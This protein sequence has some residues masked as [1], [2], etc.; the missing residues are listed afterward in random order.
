[1]KTKTDLDVRVLSIVEPIADDLGLRV[2]RLRVMSG[3]RPVLQIMAERISDGQMNVSACEALSR[4]VSS[5]LEVED[6]IRDAYVLEVSSPGLERPLTSLEDFDKYTGYLARV[7]LDR[8]VEGRKRFRG[9]LAGNDGELVGIDLD[10]EDE[11][12]FIPFDWMAEAKLIITDE[13]IDA[14]QKQRAA[15]NKEDPQNLNQQNFEV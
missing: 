11:T 13:M 8:L 7:E 1:M 12:A 10:G 4:A 15:E 6:P 2:V 14:V 3:R 9:T 5:A